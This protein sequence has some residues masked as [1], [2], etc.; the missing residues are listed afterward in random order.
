MKGLEKRCRMPD[1]GYLI[2]DA[3]KPVSGILNHILVLYC[4]HAN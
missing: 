1:T 3:A 2:P 4:N